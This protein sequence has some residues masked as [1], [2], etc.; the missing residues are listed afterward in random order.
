MDLIMENKTFNRV[1]IVNRGEIS[2]RII[3]ALRELNIESV[4]LY[5]DEDVNSSHIQLADY[6]Y[7][8]PGRLAKDTYLDCNKILEA[9]KQTKSDGVHPGYG[10]LAENL[11]FAQMVANETDA[12]FIG[13]NLKA[14]EILGNKITAK[15]LLK[16][17]K[18]PLVP[19]CE[20]A[21]G[22]FLE[23]EK[24]VKKIGYPLIL[25]ASAGGGGKGMRIILNKDDLL[26]S[27]D[28]CKRE[29][30]NYFNNDDI[31]CERYIENPRHIEVQILCDK[32]GHGV[33]LFEREC[34]IQRRHQKIIE[35]APSLA[36]SQKDRDHLGKLSL[37]IAKLVNYEGVGTVEFLYDNR[38]NFYFMEMNTRIQV[39]HP[40][41]EMLTGIDLV[42]EQIL[43]AEG[44][45]LKWQQK[46]IKAKGHSIEIRLNAEDPNNDF[47]PSTGCIKKLNL[48]SYPFA[49]I[50]SFL[51]QG[52]EPS[53]YYDSLIAKVIVWGLT[54]DEALKRLNGLLCEI[55]VSGLVTNQEFLTKI[56]NHPSFIKNEIDTNFIEKNKKS[57][58][59][60]ENISDDT[61]ELSFAAI[62]AFLAASPNHLIYKETREEKSRWNETSRQ[63]SE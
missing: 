32:H 1:L 37:Q 52:Y 34:T 39:E 22:S 19:G 31:F 17:N 43:S 14:M 58:L 56:L 5:S 44:Q 45:K 50:D 16:K 55:D 46:D 9:I 62:G 18:I 10:F 27:Y 54:R 21:L 30:L 60:E 20:K 42:K 36:I 28:S 33:H 35:E 49:R 4:A 13:P 59:A 2:I 47:V 40:V 51:S 63:L 8:L 23:L 41:T 24:M 53:S 12:Q 11:D 7:H 3:R 26:S 48:P 61:S 25:K 15:N 6:C 38:K 29:A 57:L